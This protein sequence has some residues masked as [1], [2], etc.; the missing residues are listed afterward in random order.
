LLPRTDGGDVFIM[1]DETRGPLAIPGNNIIRTSEEDLKAKL[2]LPLRTESTRGKEVPLWWNLDYLTYRFFVEHPEYDYCVT[3]DYDAC[4]NTDLKAIIA[5]VASRDIGLVAERPYSDRQSWYW[6]K[7]HH[8]NYPDDEIEGRLLCT[9]ILS[10]VAADLLLQRRR[11]MANHP[12]VFWPFC[13]VFVPTEMRRA[14]Y[15]IENLSSFGSLEHYGFRPICWEGNYNELEKYP[16]VHPVLDTNRFLNALI[17]EH[18][19]LSDIIRPRSEFSRQLRKLKF[20]N[21]APKLF[22]E[23]RVR[24]PKRLGLVKD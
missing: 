7:V 3:L 18:E 13:E 23:L 8:G 22:R 14:G 11:S 17:S 1:A 10:R 5:D 21:V 6:R 20:R 12:P 9:M 16:F 24:F 4:I 15:K 2:G 19:S